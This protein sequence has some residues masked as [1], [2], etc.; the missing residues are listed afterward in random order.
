VKLYFENNFSESWEHRPNF[1]G[2][3]FRSLYDKEN[4]NLMAPFSIYEVRELIWNND[5]NKSPDLD[6]FNFN[7]FKV[8][9]LASH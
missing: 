9:I 3:P 8:Y 7:F 2:L 4:L 5:G 1:N 6:G